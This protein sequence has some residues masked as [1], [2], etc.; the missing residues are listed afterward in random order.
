MEP[1]DSQRLCQHGLAAGLA[2]TISLP[3]FPE[4]ITKR[5]PPRRGFRRVGTTS[6]DIVFRFET[7]AA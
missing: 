4:I 5:L 7:L 3:T 1:S 6:V 2:Q